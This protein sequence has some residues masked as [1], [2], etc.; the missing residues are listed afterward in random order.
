MVEKTV[1]IVPLKQAADTDSR[2]WLQRLMAE[3]IA[4]VEQLRLEWEALQGSPDVEQRL[5]RVCRVFKRPGR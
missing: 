3:R 5:Q 2:L 1:E 4:A